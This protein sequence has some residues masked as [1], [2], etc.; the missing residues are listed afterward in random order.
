MS[1]GVA[2]RGLFGEY[3]HERVHAFLEKRS[4]RSCGNQNAD[5]LLFPVG[6]D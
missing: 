5:R 2:P 1:A 4:P 3:Y 6:A